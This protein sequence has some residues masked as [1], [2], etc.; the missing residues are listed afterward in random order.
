MVEHMRNTNGVRSQQIPAAQT[1]D[2]PLHVAACA[3][4][5]VLGDCLDVLPQLPDDSID[6]IITDPPYGIYYRSRSMKLPL[7]TVTNDGRGAYE[8]L[9]QALAAAYPKLKADAHIYIFTNW[10]AYPFMKVVVEKYFRL[11]NLLIWEKNAWTRGDLK[12]NYGYMHEDIIYAQKFVPTNPL[13]R[14]LNGKRDGNILKYKKLP[15]NYMK[16]PTQKPLELLEYLVAKSTHPG[17]TVLDMFMGSGSTC[18]AAKRQQRHYIGIE[19][20]QVW[21]DVA[22]QRVACEGA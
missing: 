13:K 14:Y 11:K 4:Q 2:N 9:D 18:L 16:H 3:S 22:K 20:E 7:R 10:Q 12:G 8:L 19:L 15:T 1:R 21:Y 6:C 17:D 5:L